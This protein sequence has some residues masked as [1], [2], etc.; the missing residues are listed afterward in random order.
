MSN[1]AQPS[2]FLSTREAAALL[3]V[4][5]KTIHK[6]IATGLP[7]IR[8]GRVIRIDRVVLLSLG[9]AT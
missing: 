1:N 6:A 9:K 4:N 7:H 3:H 2:Q 5:V 8:L